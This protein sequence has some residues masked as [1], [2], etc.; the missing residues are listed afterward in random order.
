M[1]DELHRIINYINSQKNWGNDEKIRYAYLELGKL[2]HKDPL[3]FY[4]IKN[5]LNKKEDIR[6]DID[7]VDKMMNSNNRFDS[8]VICKNSADM[9]KYIFDHTGIESDIKK[10]TV[11]TT[12]KEENKKV[13][14]IHYFIVAT[15]NDK[16]KYFLTLNPDLS[17][18]Q[19]G[20]Q[21]SHF[22]SDIPYIQTIIIEQENGEKIKQVVQSYEGEEIK[23]TVLSEDEIRAIDERIGYKF[24]NYNGNQIYADE[25]FDI[26]E[27]H[28]KTSKKKLNDGEYLDIVRCE[29]PF[30]YDMCKLLNGEST[31]DEILNNDK[32]PTKEEIDNTYIDYDKLK[33]DENVLT[34][35]KLFVLLE[36][37]MK[38][39]KKAEYDLNQYVL[40]DY[41]DLVEANDYNGL[42]K[43]FSA[44]FDGKKVTELGPY[45][46]IV[47]FKKTITMFKTI[48]TLIGQEKTKDNIRMF[49][50]SLKDVSLIFVP[51]EYLPN[52]GNRLN[53]SYI[54]NKILKSFERIFDIG[55]VGEFN[56]LELLEQI[57]IIKDVINRVFTESHFN[58]QD[59][60]VPG[61]R[62]DKS[63]LANRIY[64]T[65]LFEKET[66]KPYYLIIV[67]NS[68][69]EKDN[70]EG[71]V[72][73][74][75][76]LK[77][78]TLTTDRSMID[79]YDSFHVIKDR[80]FNLMIEQI[81]KSK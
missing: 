41:I 27:K 61:Y 52:A 48:D 19:I 7:T 15:G 66:K 78:N 31:L 59:P 34:D 58:K 57:D 2:V 70:N 5:F 42:M 11:K 60:T 72:P 54:T 25:L 64:S 37:L 53:S 4:T 8:A 80:D 30:Y 46:P 14:I 40:D 28:Y 68:Q 67:K 17:N 47:Q 56:S 10:A 26:L 32:T 44:N 24:T 18:I 49:F 79:I 22:A 73:I 6:Y 50:D 81:E 35:L 77:N 1:I 20:K 3:F 36:V 39:Y 62:D 16:K 65:V 74:L 75:F 45:N 23:H 29:T 76:D 69:N 9:L 51:D 13:E 21:T 55:H 33:L 63:P 43:T 12:Y 38:L 71:F